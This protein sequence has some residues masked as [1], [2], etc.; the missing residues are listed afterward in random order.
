MKAFTESFAPLFERDLNHLI[1]ELNKYE[2]E[3]DMWIVA[4]DIKNSAGNLALH[5]VGNLRHFFGHVMGG[6]SYERQRDKEFSVKDVDRDKMVSEIKLTIQEV[7]GV[8]LEISNEQLL[9]VFPINVLGYEM[10]T[11]YFI[12][13]LYG[14]LNYHL[15]QVNYHRR[16]LHQQIGWEA[17]S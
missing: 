10:T 1:D 4:G 16:L 13:H 17:D 2:H 8:L 5:I 3:A 14:H 12:T 9:E 6:T 7:K 11:A 15:G